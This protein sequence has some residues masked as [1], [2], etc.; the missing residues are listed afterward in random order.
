MNCSFK[1]HRRRW[2][3]TNEGCGRSIKWR[4][5]NP[6]KA[7]CGGLPQI[8][9]EAE[10]FLAIEHFYLPVICGANKPESERC[11]HLDG[12]FLCNG[13]GCGK[14]K[15]IGLPASREKINYW[16]DEQGFGVL[17]DCPR[18][19]TPEAPADVAPKQQE[20]GQ[21]DGQSQSQDDQSANET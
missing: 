7:K 21:P 10:Q 1:R 8:E 12:G 15:L 19:H 17:M 5:G 13:C 6:P 14:P 9:P 3:C 20:S 18:W 4:P 16:R 11:E 2:R